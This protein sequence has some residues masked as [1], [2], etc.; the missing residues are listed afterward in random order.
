MAPD[1]TTSKAPITPVTDL[2]PSPPAPAPPMLLPVQ[3]PVLSQPPPP[4]PPPPPMSTG[5]S[6][7]YPKLPPVLTSEIPN[8]V[9]RQPPLI[10]PKPKGK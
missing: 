3:T 10:L 4:A 8:R 1:G 9:N 6:L 5:G 2:N 7:A